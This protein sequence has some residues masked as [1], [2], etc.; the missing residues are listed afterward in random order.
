MPAA[1][2]EFLL[3]MGHGAGKFLRGS[4]CFFQHLPYLQEWAL[5][6]LQENNFP[7]NLPEDTFIFLMHIW[8][9]YLDFSPAIDAVA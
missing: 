8:A 2:Q 6:L 3:W 5:E 1:Y 4:D 7:E 9:E